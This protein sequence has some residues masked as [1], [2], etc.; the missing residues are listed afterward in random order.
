MK[1]KIILLGVHPYIGNSNGALLQSL[2]QR[3]AQLRMSPTDGR[4]G[5]SLC[6]L[7]N[8]AGGKSMSVSKHCC[9]S[10]TQQF[11]MVRNAR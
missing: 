2:H 4:R 1:V 8:S 9:N 3:G 5:T 6:S 10:C 11:D 7:M